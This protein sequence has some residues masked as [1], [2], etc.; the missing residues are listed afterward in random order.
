MR[1]PTWLIEANVY[2]VDSQ[3]LQD[4]IR[5]QGM[6]VQVVK[7]NVGAPPPRDLLGAEQLSPDGCVV[8]LG[9]LPVMEHIQR[10]KRWRPGGWCSFDKLSCSTYYSYFG[11]FLLNQNYTLLP[12]SEVIRH[13]KR[14]GSE[15]G[16][17][18]MVFI[19]P[20][21]VR[22]IFKGAV[23]SAHA[24]EQALASAR[25]D[26][27]QLVLVAEPQ[28]VVRE[29]R[30]V[31]ANGEVVAASQYYEG[32]KVAR[33]AGCP[34]EVRAFAERA[35]SSVSWRPDPLFVLDVCESQDEL[36]LV[37][38]NSFSCSGLYECDKAAVISAAA[39]CASKTW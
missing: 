25:Y 26:P 29:W 10:T 2:G 16:K 31:V 24:L 37:E 22:K 7:P 34:S 18:G 13:A 20:D 19:R 39:E 17:E 21:T 9:T 38:L 27:T 4:E 8:F 5:H 32:G 14:L 23:V 35:L 30:L 33:S 11:P 36:R 3:A 12:C 6:T 1:R 28:E 15:F